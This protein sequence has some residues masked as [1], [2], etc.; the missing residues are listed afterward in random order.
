MCHWSSERATARAIMLAVVPDMSD[1]MVAFL[2]KRAGLTG[3]VLD[4]TMFSPGMV[5]PCAVVCLGQPDATSVELLTR[6][7]IPKHGGGGPWIIVGAQ[8]PEKEVTGPA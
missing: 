6:Q 1:G 4:G 8:R 2:A 7:L 5:G 3:V